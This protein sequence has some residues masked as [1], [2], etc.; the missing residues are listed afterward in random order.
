MSGD[1]WQSH[2]DEDAA[3]DDEDVD[4]DP[5]GDKPALVRCSSCRAE[6]YEDAVV[7]PYCGDF[8]VTDTSPWSDRSILW[9]LLGILG[10]AAV[11][12]VLA[13]G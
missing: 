2:D 9:I 7:C 13:L 1:S 5:D 4:F 12:L 3:H 6:I 11:I 10:I 8:V